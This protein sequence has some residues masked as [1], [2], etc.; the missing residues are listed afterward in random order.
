[1]SAWSHSRTAVTLGARGAWAPPLFRPNSRNI[2]FGP[3]HF[4]RQKGPKM[5]LG[6]WAPSLLNKWLRPCIAYIKNWFVCRPFAC[7]R[8]SYS[9]APA[10]LSTLHRGT[11]SEGTMYLNILKTLLV[12]TQKTSPKWEYYFTVPQNMVRTSPDILRGV[13]S[14]FNPWVPTIV[15]PQF[16]CAIQ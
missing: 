3:S 9:I 15:N 11:Y 5:A 10:L 6:D 16:L 4:L 7:L 2:I 14:N 13:F 1:M 8:I 12:I